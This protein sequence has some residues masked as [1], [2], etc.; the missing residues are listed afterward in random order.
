MATIAYGC[1]MHRVVSQTDHFQ[2]CESATFH[3]SHSFKVPDIII[4]GYST[5]RLFISLIIEVA[6][7]AIVFP[8]I[9]IDLGPGFAS[10]FSWTHVVFLSGNI[11][12]AFG[13]MFGASWLMGYCVECL[14]CL[15]IM[16][17]IY[18]IILFLFDRASLS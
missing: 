18:C 1:K 12:I 11:A 8:A 2:N 5:Y 3:F 10:R 16:I 17:D 9:T 6:L 13:N 4:R 15:P 14:I 7:A